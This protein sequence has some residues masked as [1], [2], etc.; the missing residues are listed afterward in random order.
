MALAMAL[1][2]AT[3]TTMAMA[4]AAMAMALAIRCAPEVASGKTGCSWRA[5]VRNGRTAPTMMAMAIL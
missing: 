4:L 1:A 3:A 5:G 2:P